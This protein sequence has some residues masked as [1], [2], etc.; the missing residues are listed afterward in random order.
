MGVSLKNIFNE[1]EDELVVNKSN[2]AI[3]I[4][5]YMAIAI[6][7]FII[8]AVILKATGFL[9]RDAT[10]RKNVIH[11]IK[12]IQEAVQLKA[13]EYMLNPSSVTLIGESLENNPLTLDVNGVTEE[14]RYGYYLLNP[15]TLKELTTALILPDE[16]YIVNYD[17]Y[18]VINWSG[19]KYKG[20]RYHA[21]E[22]LL[23]VEKEQ[24]PVKK[25][26]I[27]TVADLEKIRQNPNGYFK[28]SGNLDLSDYALGEGWKPIEQFGG[29][30]DG[31]GYTISNLT[32]HRP[33]SINVGL[34]GT[35]TG[36]A[37]ITNVKFE[38]AN[39]SGGQYVGVLAGVCAGNVSHVQ[40]LS[41]SV[42]GQTNYVGGLVGSQNGGTI[43]N[44]IVTLNT[45]TGKQDVGGIVGILTSGT[46]TKSGARTNIIGSESTGGVIGSVSATL[47]GSVAYIHEV[48][49]NVQITGTTN[50]GGIIGEIEVIAGN[51]VD[52][53]NSYSKG[54]IN[55]SNRNSGGLVGF[56]SSVGVATLEFGSLYTTLDILEKS[57][58]SGGCIGY[59]DIAITSAISL[60]DCFWEKDLAPGEVLNSVGS[61]KNNTFTISFDDKTY[62]EM[63]IRN[64]FVNWD[65]DIWGIQERVNTPYLNWEI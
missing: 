20:M 40:V 51:K 36:T 64:T 43:S 45:I 26:I 22:D 1:N 19:I 34:F 42:A 41:G 52:L 50:V 28:L 54:A 33:S 25:Q 62:A 5:I 59:T 39:V 27:R 9:E 30:L 6:V 21:I 13:N 48:C 61:Q 10:R 11:D 23:L 15:E 60:S 3:R 63:R 35:L 18:D 47:V 12:V 55:G 38:K 44:C 24:E 57:S 17:T 8:V 14:Y 65:F 49:S 37:K 29:T 7:F 2:K 16:N 32:V 53:K 56:V 46:L 4:L 31:R 58:T